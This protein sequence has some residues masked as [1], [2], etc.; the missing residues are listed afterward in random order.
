MLSFQ[1]LN[2]QRDK[3]SQTPSA[4]RQAP[5]V[6]VLPGLIHMKFRCPTDR[7]LNEYV[8]TCHTPPDAAGACSAMV[9]G[10]GSSRQ[11]CCRGRTAPGASPHCHHSQLHIDGGVQIANADDSP[12]LTPHART[13][14]SQCE[15]PVIQT[16]S[17]AGQL[18]EKP[19][20]LNVDPPACGASRPACAL[21]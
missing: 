17:A 3:I 1:M 8:R 11:S 5:P 19:K 9:C 7:T 2:S 20:P 13:R 12:G 18:E 16:H 14:H 21:A 15:L 4:L 6:H 10:C